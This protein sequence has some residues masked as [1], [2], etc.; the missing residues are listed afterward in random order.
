M[1]STRLNE[2]QIKTMMK[3]IEGR[4]ED[5]DLKISSWEEDREQLL[6]EL[7]KYNEILEKNSKRVLRVK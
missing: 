6:F 5:I 4:I 7:D 3:I 2:M 1:I